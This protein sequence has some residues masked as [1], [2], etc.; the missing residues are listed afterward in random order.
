MMFLNSLQHIE[1]EIDTATIKIFILP[2]KKKKL[3]KAE[4]FSK[5]YYYKRFQD[6]TR[7]CTI[8]ASNLTSLHGFHVLNAEGKKL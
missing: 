8:A 4:Q 3:T 7:S 2:K 5:I 6:P 1:R